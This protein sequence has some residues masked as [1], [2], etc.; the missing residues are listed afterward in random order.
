MQCHERIGVCRSTKL[1]MVRKIISLPVRHSSVR[2]RGLRWRLEVW[3][4]AEHD[5][6]S[7]HDAGPLHHR[8][9]LRVVWPNA[10]V[11]VW[12]SVLHPRRM[13]SHR[14]VADGADFRVLSAPTTAVLSRTSPVRMVCRH[15]HVRAW[16]GVF[17]ASKLLGGLHVWRHGCQLRCVPSVR[18]VHRPSVLRLV[19]GLIDMLTVLDRD[20]ELRPSELRIGLDCVSVRRQRHV[21]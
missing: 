19:C 13:L 7:V 4:H 1:W 8:I 21:G 14:H 3:Q 6:S 11:S 20:A 5:V 2:A 15:C 17:S 16:H 18:R 9:A 12:Q 10:A